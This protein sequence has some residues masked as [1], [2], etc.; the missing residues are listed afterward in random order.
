MDKEQKKLALGTINRKYQELQQ[1]EAGQ[2]PAWR[3]CPDPPS[4]EERC[5]YAD[6]NLKEVLRAILPALP[7]DL[8]EAAQACF[9]LR[10]QIWSMEYLVA[11]RRAKKEASPDS[12]ATAGGPPVSETV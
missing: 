7:K 1:L 8:R 9:D 3:T 10:N 6:W 5:M 2:N 4:L 12:L 11:Y